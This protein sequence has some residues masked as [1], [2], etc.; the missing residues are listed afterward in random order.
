MCLDVPRV[1]RNGI[2]ILEV[3]KGVGALGGLLESSVS[4]PYGIKMGTRVFQSR[5]VTDWVGERPVGE[6]WRPPWR[7]DGR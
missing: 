1:A 3:N 6:L 7:C 5:V 2:V 4:R